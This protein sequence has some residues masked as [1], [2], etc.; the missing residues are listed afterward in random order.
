MRGDVYVAATGRGD[1][2]V[3]LR[4]PCV[5]LAHVY[6]M[7][8]RRGRTGVQQIYLYRP[9]GACTQAQRIPSLRWTAPGAQR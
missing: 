6:Y 7:P 1:L 4:D 2:L 9:V 3:P 5:R 8:V